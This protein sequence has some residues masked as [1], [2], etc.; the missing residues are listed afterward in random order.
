[1]NLLARFEPDI[2][3]YLSILQMALTSWTSPSPDWRDR[4]QLRAGFLRHYQ[5]IRSSV[6]PDRLL[7]FRAEDGWAPL[8]AFLEKPVPVEGYPYVNAGNELF[9]IHYLLIAVTALSLVVKGLLW[10][11][12]VGVVL[13][14]V[15]YY[16]V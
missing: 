16:Y 11:T 10:L 4:S 2:G 6:P 13:F 15:W 8:C 1:M 12:P 3:K 7:E 14:G 5:H 9:H